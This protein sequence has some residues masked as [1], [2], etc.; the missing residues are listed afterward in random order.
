MRKA[1]KIST[2]FY[3]C[4]VITKELFDSGAK[5]EDYVSADIIAVAQHLR[6]KFGRIDINTWYW[7][8]SSQYRGFR[9]QDCPIGAKRSAHKSGLALDLIFKDTTPI[10]VQKYIKANQ[11]EFYDLGL[12]RI[13]S[14]LITKTWLHI[15][16]KDVGKKDTIYIFNP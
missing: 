6:T 9:P 10:E 11:K 1:E 12:R 3:D 13:E 4:E 15:D 7:G 16:C 5:V 2:N 8:W 14:A